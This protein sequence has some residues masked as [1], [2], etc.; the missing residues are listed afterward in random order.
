MKEFTG[1]IIEF[2]TAIGFKGESVTGVLKKPRGRKKTELYWQKYD[3]SKDKWFLEFN[4][5]YQEKSE[6]FIVI[7]KDAPRYI[8][9]LIRTQGYKMYLLKI[10]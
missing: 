5:T 2:I 9:Y 4:E 1:N 7:R 6:K 3:R 8:E 10:E